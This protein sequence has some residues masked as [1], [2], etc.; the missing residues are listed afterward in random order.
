VL[1]AFLNVPHYK[2]GARSMESIVAMSFLMGKTRFERSALPSEA[3][4]DLHVPGRTFLALVQQ[5]MAGDYDLE[6][7]EEAAMKERDDELIELLARA[8]HEHFCNER[9]AEEFV[10]GEVTNDK[11]TPKTHCSLKPFEQLPLDEQ[12]QNRNNAR[13]FPRKL[14]FFKY[15]MTPARSSEPPFVF[16]PDEL[17]TLARKEQ[18]RWER[19][20]RLAGW[21][22]GPDKDPAELEHPD[23]LP[24]TKLT[25]EQLA[26]H[27]FYSD[28][29]TDLTGRQLSETAKQKNREMVA[30][31]PKILAR[32]GF[33][34]VKIE[35]EP[36]ELSRK[37]GEPAEPE[38]ESAA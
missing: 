22:Y 15:A 33:T 9:T 25:R 36:E 2:H 3:Q 21:H 38:S 28:E 20:K 17:E 29:P 18:E 11:S 13:D 5:I 24:W 23:L 26:S 1:R 35:D 16:H 30:A 32:V 4:L 12:S 27:E 34:I 31:I 19:E 10:Y 14:A 7:A 6:D 8:V 37:E